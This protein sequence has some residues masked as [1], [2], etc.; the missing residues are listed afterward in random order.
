MKLVKLRIM[1]CKPSAC[2]HCDGFVFKKLLLPLHFKNRTET[3]DN[4]LNISK[5]KDLK[6][7]NRD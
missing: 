1:M 3:I 5:I 6:N 2:F 7:E 4:Y